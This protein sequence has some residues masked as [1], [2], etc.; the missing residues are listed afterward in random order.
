VDA[1]EEEI[2]DR[3]T[4]AHIIEEVRIEIETRS[5]HRDCFDFTCRLVP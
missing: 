4:A 1:A 2:L 5:S 3:A